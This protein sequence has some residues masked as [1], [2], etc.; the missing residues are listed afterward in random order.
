MRILDLTRLYP[1]PLATMLMADMGADVIKI[2]DVNSP[3]YIRTT[4]PFI[5]EISSAWLALNR[6][7][8]SLALDFKNE[9]GRQVFFDLVKTADIVIEGFRPGVLDKTGIGYESAKT[10][11]SKI[12][13]VSVTGYGQTGPRAN[14]AGHDINYIGYT[15]ALDLNGTEQTGPLMPGVQMAD[16]AG[17]AYM[18]II[19]ILSA[20]WSRDRT[21]EGQHI[22][23]AMTDGVLPLMALQFSQFWGLGQSLSRDE[24]LLSGSLASYGTYE[25][26]DGKYVA[27]GAL[28]PRFWNNFCALIDQPEWRNMSYAQGEERDEIRIEL[29]EIFKT[30]TRDEWASLAAGKDACLTPI[31]TMGEVKNDPQLQAREMIVEQDHPSLG[32][33]SAIGFPLKFSQTEPTISNPAPE[34]GEHSREILKELEYDEKR[35]ENL[36]SNGVVKEPTR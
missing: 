27:L 11:N 2:E 12:I 18:A 34:L 26:K 33:I 15:G 1:G 16:V 3:D 31:L 20:L 4:P 14:D 5:G 6:S 25:C 28:E 10:H 8:R 36:F 23:I 35:I 32:K 30:K 19:A 17:G 22:D 29:Q 9:K 7:K 13:Y 24:Q 21:G